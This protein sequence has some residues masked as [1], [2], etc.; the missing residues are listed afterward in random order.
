MSR[1]LTIGRVALATA[2]LVCL[3]SVGGAAQTTS[4][5][6]ETKA[7]DVIA[8]EGNTLVVRLPEGTREIT[9]PDSFRFVIDGKP[10]SVHELKP[11]M[12]GTAQITTK[13]TVTPVT[14]TEVKNGTV[15]MRAGNS[16]MVRTDNDVKMFSQEDVDKRR[17]RLVRNGEPAT[18]TDFR[19][20]DRLSATIVTSKPPRVVTEKEVQAIL[21]KAGPASMATT[22]SSGTRTAPQ[23]TGSAATASA[24]QQQA[25][26]APA[27]TL[28]KTASPLP[29]AGLSGG[30]FL[31]MALALTIKRRRLS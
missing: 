1:C 22:A 19:E 3:W 7:F 2:A 28:P 18:I 29:L 13:T 8:V 20:G 12:R 11:G 4:S 9:V 6:T 27:R 23:A 31:A 5:A 21:A 25:S 15:V 14:V 26:A 17:M 30:V 16:L 10:M 24:P